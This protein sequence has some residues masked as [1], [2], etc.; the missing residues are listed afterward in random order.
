[1]L[2]LKINKIRGMNMEL[3]QTTLD[4]VKSENK[5]EGFGGWLILVAV[6]LVLAIPQRISA[7]QEAGDVLQQYVIESSLLRSVIYGELITNGLLLVLNF[8]ML[9]LFFKKKKAFVKVWL[10]VLISAFIFAVVDEMV[11]YFFVDL[12]S[13]GFPFRASLTSGVAL[14]IWG[15]YATRSKRVK[16]TFIK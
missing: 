9:F 12:P 16:N 15:S 4:Q 11:I 10:I 5:L 2:N 3:Q 6:G 7:I 13:L 14:L 8:V 1:V